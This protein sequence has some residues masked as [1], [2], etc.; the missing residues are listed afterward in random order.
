MQED[1]WFDTHGASIVHIKVYNLIRHVHNGAPLAHMPTK[2]QL[3]YKVR[4]VMSSLN[5]TQALAL[6][7][8]NNTLPRPHLAGGFRIEY[9][10]QFRVPAPPAVGSECHSEPSTA[11]LLSSDSDDATACSD[12][13]YKE[14]FNQFCDGFKPYVS[15]A[16]TDRR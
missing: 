8:R 2:P 5:Q 3:P 14:W 15:G 16:F 13:F 7:M 10:V 11:R 6:E 4:S 12:A 1:F 9:R